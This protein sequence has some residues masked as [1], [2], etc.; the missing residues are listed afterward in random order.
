MDA[1]EF[2][3]RIVLNLPYD[4]NEQQVQLIAA[5]ARFCSPLSPQDSI[6]M[7]NG[8]AGTGKTSLTGALV[9]SLN[10]VGISSVLLAPT[11]RAAKVFGR[12]AKHPAYTI[13]RKI[14][15]QASSGDMNSYVAMVAENKHRNTIF[16]VDEASMIGSRNDNGSDVLEDLIHYVYSGE[17]CR[18]ILLGDTAQLPP[19]GCQFS[20][21]MTVNVL[22]SFGLRVT[23]ATLTATVRQASNSG[24]L[25]NATWLRR[26][27]LTDPLPTPML[28]ASKFADVIPVLSEDLP[29]VLSEAYSRDGLEETILVTRSNQRAVGFNLAIRGNILEKEEYLC[30]DELVLVAKNNYLWSSKVKGIDFIANGDVALVTKIYGTET[31]YGFLFA[32]A[33]IQFPDRDIELDAKLLLSTLASDAPGLTAQQSSELYQYCLNNPDNF[34][35]NTPMSTRVKSLKTDPY[36]NALQVKY[37]YAVTCH[38]AQG[39]QWKNV[40]IDMGYIAPEAQGMEF[41]RWL[42]TAITRATHRLYIINPSVEVK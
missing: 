9:R 13:H 38:K 32:D 11:G 21:A 3:E 30:R 24:I 36:F 29:E 41:Y 6:F 28:V 33:K 4:P 37:A 19:V 25:Y 20:P 22:K 15:R 26:A 1:L 16:I 42:Y 17:N 23:R 34:A 14:Y 39:G 35:P 2:A 8:Y 27:M 31:K 18:L 5:L 7:L 40:F 10:E 12:F